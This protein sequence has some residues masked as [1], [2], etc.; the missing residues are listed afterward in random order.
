MQ[1][2]FDVTAESSIPKESNKA[3]VPQLPTKKQKRTKALSDGYRPIYFQQ[4]R[5]LPVFTLETI[6]VMLRDP[7]IRLG[8]AM[9]AAPIAG[10][11]FTY[12]DGVT[13][14][15]KPNWVP[16]V[17]ARNPIVGAWV[18]RQLETIWNNYLNCIL[19][20]QVWG[21]AAGE[22][23][24]RLSEYD[25]IEINTLEARHARDCRLMVLEKA[26]TKWGMQI[27]NIEGVGA[28]QLPFPYCFFVNFRPQDGDLYSEPILLGAYSPWADKWLNGGALDVR[29]L[30][31]HKDAYGGRKVSYPSEDIG[32]D[33]QDETIPARDLA[34]QIVEQ[35]KSGGVAT[36][37]SDRDADGH[38]KWEVSDPVVSSNPQHILQYPKDCDAEI[39]H[40]LEIP[41]GATSNDGAGSWEGKA[42]PLAAFYSGLDS[43]VTQMLCDLRCTLDPLAILNFGDEGIEYE[44]MHKPLA[45][46][47]MEQ[48]GQKRQGQDYSGGMNAPGP[49][50]G[51]GQ[52]ASPVTMGLATVGQGVLSA[53]SL[54]RA[55]KQAL[56]T[57]EIV[58]MAAERAPAGYTHDAPLV[59]NGEKYVGGMFIPGDQLSHASEEQLQEI[60]SGK[61]KDAPEREGFQPA[62][63]LEKGPSHD[64]HVMH[65]IRN[66]ELKLKSGHKVKVQYDSKPATEG[67]FV[68]HYDQNKTKTEAPHRFRSIEEA[69][70]FAAAMLH[71]KA[72]PSM[73]N[74]QSSGTVTKEVTATSN[75]PKPPQL[76][77]PS[78]PQKTKKTLGSE[79]NWRYASKDFFSSGKVA[80]FNDNIAALEVLKELE[81]EKRPA[82]KEEQEIL[83]KYVGWGQMPEA[84][85]YAGYQ[86][87]HAWRSR[88]TLLRNM[89]GEEGYATARASTTNGHYTHPSV[90]EAHWKMAKKLG[91]EGGRFLEPAVGGG[92]YLG[93]MPQDLADK[94]HVTAVD[95]DKG[96]AELT[97]ALYPSAN[98]NNAPFQ[99]VKT[100]NDYYDLVATNV[101]FDGDVK[102]YSP[103]HKMSAALHDYYFLRSVDT[104]K[105][106]A[107]IMQITSAGTMD[108][109][110]P[111][112]R[113]VLDDQTELVSA[114]RFPGDTHKE[115]AGTEVVTDMLILRKKNPA[116]SEV[117]D[118]TPKE[119]KPSRE[120]FTGTT[121][122]SLGRLY[123]W[124]DGVRVAKPSWNDTVEVPDPNGGKPIRINKYFQDHPDNILGKLDRTGTMY[125][126]GMKN[127]TRQD[128]YEE[129]LQKIIDDLPSNI[130]RTEKGSKAGQ[131]ARILTQDQYHQGQYVLKDGEVYQHDN[132]ALSP[133][134]LSGKAKERAV[135]MIGIKDAAR[136]VIAAQVSGQDAEDAR[137]QLNKAYDSYVAKHGPLHDKANR[138]VMEN[139]PD[140]A[141]LL[142]LENY[143]SSN[144]KAD[145]ADIFTKNT[146]NSFD[147]ADSA[148]DIVAA[149]GISLHET[150]GINVERIA[151]LLGKP[152]DAIGQEMMQKGL[153]FKNLQGN[154]EPAS[155]YLSG[156]TRQKL[157]EARAAAETDP[158]YEYNVRALEKSQPEDIAPEDIGVTLASPWVPTKFLEQFAAEV[159][160]AEVGDVRVK[161]SREAGHS[162]SYAN[163]RLEYMA[164]NYQVWGD[165]AE[166]MQAACD[167]KTIKRYT[168]YDGK[169]VID[170]A[171][172]DEMNS[173][174]QTLKEQFKDWV[175]ED[176]GRAR[177]LAGL[178]NESNNNYVET[179]FDG[180]H[181]TLPGMKA[182][183]NMRSTSK[184]FVYR[185]I[186]TGKGLAAHEVGV[187]KTATMVASAMELRR[188]G[189]AKKPAI[190]VKKANI[191]QFAAE[192]Q[193]LYPGA[194]ILTLAK[195]FTG[196]ERAKTLQRIA[197]G[198]YDMIILTH[199]AMQNMKMKPESLK[200]FIGSELDELEAALVEAKK[201][202]DAEVKKGGKKKRGKSLTKTIES[203]KQKLDAYLSKVLSQD[204][205]DAIY[206]EDTG[207]DQLFVDEAHKFKSLPVVTKHQ[208]VKGIP[209]LTSASARAMDMLAR[210]RYLNEKTNGRGVVF[211][212]GTPITNTMAE[213]Y[214]MQRFLQ[215][216]LLQERG[217]HQF[218]NWA[219]T[220]GEMTNDVEFKLKGEMA[221]TQRFARFMN[222]PELRQLSS[223]FM[224]IK[225]AE[226][227]PGLVRPNKHDKV[228]VIPQSEQMMEFMDEIKERAKQVR[229]GKSDRLVRRADGTMGNDSPLVINND[230]R[231]GSI[232]L[233]L[234]DGKYADDP[235]S[236]SNTAIK[237]IL[238]I[239]HSDPNATQA[240]FSDI[241]IHDTNKSG[242]SLFD[243]MKRKLVE[244][245]IPAEHI[246]DFS[247]ESVKD[248]KRE[249][250]QNAM[251]RGDVR[252]AFGST[253]RLGTGTNIQTKLKAIHHLDTPYVPAAL[254]Q[255]D[256]RAHRQGNTYKDVDVYKYVQEGSADHLS[257]QTLARKSGFINQFMKGDKSL[258]SMEDIAT[259]SM[260]P[261]QMMALATGNENLMRKIG[262][263]QE[264][265]RLER[266]EKRHRAQTH[267]IASKLENA[268]R[269]RARLKSL[270]DQ[271]I[272]D[273]DHV[274]AHRDKNEFV[275]GS[276]MDRKLVDQHLLEGVER[277]RY[278]RQVLGQYKGMEVKV[279][280][281]EPLLVTPSGREIPFNPSLRSL[282]ATIRRLEKDPEQTSE[283][284][285][286]FD[287]DMR[288][289]E[290]SKGGP[291]KHAET[292]KQ[293]RKELAEIDPPTNTASEAA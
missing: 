275:Y 78:E 278:G 68:R 30:F 3:T 41:D 222:L 183:F 9:R 259:D 293:K 62:P 80:K 225:R 110:D 49:D 198:D 60:K 173:R 236:K 184:D 39:R 258:R 143:N 69:A 235:N 37:P 4:H 101:P 154:W 83:S 209:P 281:G 149:T 134:K 211:A 241:G 283:N 229:G 148:H 202:E 226:D 177:E 107:L 167:S 150:G 271:A 82:T 254:E 195:N 51:Q 248:V 12:K 245:G 120:G 227:V 61:K 18:L 23:T 246:V 86:E 249:E 243:E 38:P 108:K 208:Q 201:A 169:R 232:D 64:R 33:G 70:D 106:G 264:V 54:I 79:G 261:E 109:L 234:A 260:S 29:R 102:I 31:M 40:G 251:R 126:G 171:A 46:T 135:G 13:Q 66:R 197:T 119:A 105:P 96:S 161:F 115:N 146:M 176:E 204:D 27:K 87:E 228:V 191:E 125:T 116:I 272:A 267:A 71:D 156:N 157:A 5:D 172:T 253:E 35:I 240:V 67:Y 141:F 242:F 239:Y 90:V 56:G 255:R 212:T 26:R 20:S 89:L 28:I 93:F 155:L 145:K 92:Y 286:N 10:V 158:I 159:L 97:Q 285:A 25:L 17:K 160:G 136:A 132:G 163:D 21:Y 244:A 153:A 282:D 45:Q 14:D 162:I 76:S 53:S 91:F 192:A 75:A 188:L 32:V 237:K 94:T 42:I 121:V 58:T 50:F 98:V 210:T 103:T 196:S 6:R 137:S 59:I 112:V 175:W 250:A 81:Q 280:Y 11:E 207:I 124:V 265:K 144:K 147:R 290:R 44:I 231:A 7:E 190:A 220:F 95:M 230:A 219:D 88:R 19:R 247:D 151:D 257:W 129:K 223:E 104:A 224:D 131:D 114:I 65:L 113:Q 166:V 43:W 193:D 57:P 170:Q 181:L 16:G 118:E 213:L 233:R 289:L 270:H 194:R 138:S 256:G 203:R 99:K 22:V 206:F 187:G 182:D 128:D 252:I 277:N 34:N 288:R 199:E 189:L 279:K 214:N 142:A 200:K 284:M 52:E 205:K 127:V 140:I 55:A 72:K 273:R 216:D 133:L 84:F 139:D 268:P 263:T 74:P 15:G 269:E 122:D 287:E 123:H 274:Q 291:F 100:P 164:S 152:V 165:F 8:L 111:K 130:V 238:E 218:D 262:V 292:L 63:K 266:L 73:G 185:V 47:A 2:Q 179:H 217:I 215:Y 174:V 168:E 276:T 85:E 221:E 77:Q 117:T 186:A 36:I 180:S 24:L 1:W 48:Q 178:Y